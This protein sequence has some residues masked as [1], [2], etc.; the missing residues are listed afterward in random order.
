MG[1]EAGEQQ[2]GA[3][4][5]GKRADRGAPA[6]GREKEVLQ[7]G[8]DVFARATDFDVVASSADA[9]AQGFFGVKLGAQLIEVGDFEFGAVFEFAGGGRK[10]AEQQAQQGGFARAVRAD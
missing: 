8:G 10:V 2:A 3:F 1:K 7:V 4:A 6:F 9:V 5:A